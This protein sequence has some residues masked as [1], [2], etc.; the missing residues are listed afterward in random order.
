[1]FNNFPVVFA[2]A[3]DIFMIVYTLWVLSL[4]NDGKMPWGLGAAMA[5]WLGAL[6][7]GLS[8]Q[9]LFPENISGITFLLIIFCRRR[10]CRCSV[11]WRAE[12]SAALAWAKPRAVVNVAGCTNIFW[13]GFSDAGR[14]RS[15]STNFWHH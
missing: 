2:I 13:C 8:N 7:I 4:N 6:H 10:A 15:A 12:A 9:L 14:S 3:L 1:M 5:V 11:I